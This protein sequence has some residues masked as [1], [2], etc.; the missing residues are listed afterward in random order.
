MLFAGWLLLFEPGQPPLLLQCMRLVGRSASCDASQQAINDTYQHLYVW[1]LLGFIAAG[2]VAI[3]LI[4]FLHPD[5][6]AR[7]AVGYRAIS[8]G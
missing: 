4:H 2:F 3:V 7:Q 6:R 5:R 1:P 8:R